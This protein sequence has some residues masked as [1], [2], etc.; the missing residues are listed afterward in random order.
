MNQYFLLLG[1][2]SGFVLGVFFTW[3]LTYARMRQIE[4]NAST[5]KEKMQ[6]ELEQLKNEA[7]KLEI[8][9]IQPKQL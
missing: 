1:P 2:A 8:K 6:Q 7:N 5:E 4:Q 9:T 3:F